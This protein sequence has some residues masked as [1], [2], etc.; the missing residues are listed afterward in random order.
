V[1]YNRVVQLFPLRAAA[2]QAAEPA[3][4]FA[5]KAAPNGRETP[6]G[7]ATNGLFDEEPPW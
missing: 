7:T 3:P 1:L 4:A 5:E 6:N 2:A